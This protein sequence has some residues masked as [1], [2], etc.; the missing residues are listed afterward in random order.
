MHGKGILDSLNGKIEGTWNFGEKNG[1]FKKIV[2]DGKFSTI[3]YKDNIK[4]SE[5]LEINDKNNE[6][7]N[8]KKYN[9]IIKVNG[10]N[11][12]INNSN[13]IIDNQNKILSLSIDDVKNE[14]SNEKNQ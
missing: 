9:G 5:D 7:E 14:K 2:K 13:E 10:G 8:D 1:I 3:K 4:I 6:K 12:I 11:K